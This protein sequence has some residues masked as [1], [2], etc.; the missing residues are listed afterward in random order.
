[1]K[2]FLS[3][4]L[5]II[6]ATGMQ[7]QLLWKVSG[8]GLEKPSYI[9][10]TYHLAPSTFA[11]S[12]KGMKDA[13]AATE[14]VYGEL[15]M[16]DMIKP[17]NIKAMQD[18][19]I[20]PAGT[21]LD[22]LLDADEMSRLNAGL[23]EMMGMDMTNATV[24][25]QLKHLTPQALLVQLQM[26]SYMKKTP[27]FDAANTIDNHFQKVAMMNGKPTGGLE[28]TAFQIRTLFKSTTIERQKELLMCFIDNMEMN[29]KL[30][31][32]VTR[33][34]FSQD[35]EVLKKA[36]DMKYNSSCDATD[37]EEETL[38]YRRNANWVKLMPEIMKRKATLFAV[39]AAHLAGEKGVPELLKKAGYKVEG[40][41]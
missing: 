2:K 35:M 5:L 36:L 24:A 34:Y 25:Q 16:S 14:Q 6:A 12:I 1:M 19:M 27:G 9:V 13:M 15:D 21:T 10:G 38:I 33:G 28:T 11:E 22:K 39:G 4:V 8:K 41:K 18:A 20:L 17:E 23:K 32:M 7:A 31:D 3:T 37:E 26:L 30:T 40:I 29:E